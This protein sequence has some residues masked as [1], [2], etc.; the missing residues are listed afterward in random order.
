VSLAVYEWLR[1]YVIA[2]SVLVAIAGT[3]QWRRFPTFKVEN[4]Y[5]WLALVA[6]NLSNLAGTA[7]ALVND[8]PGGFRN[9]IVALAETWLL[10][11]VLYHPFHAWR[12]R[13]R[14]D[15]L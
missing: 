14:S 5:A 13:R 3:L 6:L 7:E 15:D 10:V 1:Y 8:V 9:Y 4:Q 11:A 2:V 12:D